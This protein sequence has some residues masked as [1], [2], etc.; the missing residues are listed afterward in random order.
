MGASGHIFSL[1]ILIFIG[2]AGKKLGIFDETA[3]KIFSSF[4]LKLT[5][6]CL[7]FVSFLRPFSRELLGE[8]GMALGLSFL[9][10]AF[11]FAVAAVYPFLLGLKGKERGVHRF[12]VI[13]SNVGYIGY[14]LVRAV[15]GEDYLFHLSMANI[16]FHLLAY[17]AGAWFI[18]KEGD[19]KLRLSWKVFIN[20]VVAATALG[21]AVYVCSIHLPDFLSDS[22]RM[23]GEITSP[24]SMLIVGIT[25]AGM[26][27]K[28]LLGRWQ[29]Y[30]TSIMRL[31]VLPLLFTAFF[32]V[33]GIRGPLL[34][35]SA[36]FSATP[37]AAAAAMLAKSLGG[38]AEEA[39]ALVFISTFLS[40]FTMP[41]VV[42]I[43]SGI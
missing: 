10:Y 20:P 21:L 18:A 17:S 40:L 32:Y 36:L 3:A 9:I 25:M 7:I 38:D 22:L 34:M 41:L 23:A 15:M 12:V 37:A 1:F 19:A 6:P 29:N 31:L 42:H 27:V 33:L 4:V 26:S 8:G 2:F 24:L 35:L 16:P 30:L 14:P 28:R 13:F 5:L 11:S 39:S 43:V